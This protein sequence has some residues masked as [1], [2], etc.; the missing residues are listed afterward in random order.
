GLGGIDVGLGL[1][2][3]GLED[4][5]VDAGD[6]LVLLHDRVEVGEQLLDLAGD[7]AADLHEDH[8][9]EVAGGRHG[10][11]QG[12]ALDPGGPVLGGG[13]AALGVE[14][15]PHAEP[16]HCGDDHE[17]TDASH[18]GVRRGQ[19]ISYLGL[20]AGRASAPGG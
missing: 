2:D 16:D 18:H 19:A 4:L 9:V 1:G 11:G 8:R 5:G 10:R 6:D 17:G 15:A 3:L 12:S 13:A 7:L 14:V 20:T